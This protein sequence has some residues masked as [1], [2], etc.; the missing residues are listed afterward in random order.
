MPQPPRI[1]LADHRVVIRAGLRALLGEVLPAAEFGE[2]V[3][4]DEAVA[5]VTG[6]N[7]DLVVLALRLPGG[8]G[9]TTLQ[10]MRALRSQLPI[11][12]FSNMDERKMG[13]AAIRGGATGYVAKSA[14]RTSIQAAVR[15]ALQH[16]GV[17]SG[18]ICAEVAQ[19]LSTWAPGPSALSPRE[20]EVL[21]AIGTGE[22]GKEIAA[23]LKLSASSVS[24]YR[25]RI[26]EKL[27]LRTTADLLRHVVEH[28]LQ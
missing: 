24:T 27:Q 4:A 18:E 22:S 10:R 9:F 13:L 1:L 20:I 5:A 14:S 23:R 7:W 3:S 28:R 15:D 26:L 2:A 25:S 21:L 6:A 16:R 11:L 17:A 8:V 12:I 19:S